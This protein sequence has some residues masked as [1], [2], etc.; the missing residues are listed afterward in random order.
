MNCP[1]AS[2]RPASFVP[3]APW[4]L[5]L[6]AWLVSMAPAALAQTIPN[7]SFELNT[8]N[9]PPGTVFVNTAITG[10][11]VSDPQ[12]IGLNPAGGQNIFTDNGAVPSGTRVAFINSGG[13]IS[14]TLSTTITGLAVG[15]TYRLQFRANCSMG[16]TPGAS[17]RINGGPPLGFTASPAVGGS[18]AYRTITF[19]FRATSTS[20]VLEIS[21]TS[22]G[23]STLLIDNFNISAVASITVAN[24]NDSGAGSLRAALATAAGTSQANIIL[25]AS[26]LPGSILQLASELAVDDPGGVV[27]DA[28][29]F[30]GGLTVAGTNGSR[31]FSTTIAT[32][33][34]LRGL[35]LMAGH[36]NA[37]DGGAI[38][39]EGTLALSGCTIF[40]CSASSLTLGTDGGGG[41]I[42]NFGHLSLERCTL[43]NN[44]TLREGGAIR[45]AEDGTLAVTH[46]TISGNTANYGSG[47]TNLGRLTVTNSIIA[48]NTAAN[49]GDDIDN[50]GSSTTTTARVGANLIQELTNEDGATDSGPAALTADPQLGIL[51]SNGGPTATMA[52]ALT[53]PA[54]NAVSESQRVTVTGTSGTFTLTFSGQTTSALPVNST[55]AEVETARNNLSTIG[56]VGGL[57]TVTKAGTGNIYTVSFGD[58]LAGDDVPQMTTAGAAATVVTLAGGTDQRGRPIVGTADL[59][60]YE[61]QTGNFALSAATFTTVEGSPAVIT[62]SR[63]TEAIGPVTVRLIT[64]AGAGATGATEPADYTGRPNTTASDVVFAD[65]ETTKNVSIPTVIDAVTEGNQ[66]LHYDP[67]HP[68]RHDGCDAGHAANGH[69]EDRGFH[70]GDEHE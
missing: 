55:P 24:L 48:R 25:F 59:G 11:M 64:T 67:E 12:E 4:L 57:V 29:A 30:P 31:I 2:H 69:G 68:H 27:I 26:N 1:A 23:F 65:G 35:N 56:G 46:C 5:M 9:N 16:S 58:T 60:A 43:Q 52:I 14:K 61:I 63:G 15:T 18:A 45:N 33:M 37:D 8:F 32:S 54:R 49:A 66:T 50:S 28:S 62:I 42:A 20:A 6:G 41:A 22:Q 51:T 10:W 38:L 70:P 3:R 47:I 21:N 53:S 17:C 13:N 36:V 39:N 40:N 34:S 44:L 7:P 19:L